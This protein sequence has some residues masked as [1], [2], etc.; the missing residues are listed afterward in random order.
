MER[1]D[2][3]GN[4]DDSISSGNMEQIQRFI[5][6]GIK[7]RTFVQCSHF[8]KVFCAQ[9]V[10]GFNFYS[11]D[12]H[13]AMIHAFIPVCSLAL[14]EINF[15]YYT[16]PITLDDESPQLLKAKKKAM[17]RYPT[18]KGKIQIRFIMQLDEPALQENVA[19]LHTASEHCYSINFAGVESFEFINKIN[20]ICELMPQ[21]KL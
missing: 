2:S 12:Q 17:I 13:S 8:K 18:K 6:H 1:L 15:Q 5:S 4:S 19:T 10:Q 20:C 7:K 16:M 3:D 21:I 11:L 9:C 14:D